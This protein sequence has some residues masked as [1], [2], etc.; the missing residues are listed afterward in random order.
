MLAKPALRRHAA[1]SNFFFISFSLE[2]IVYALLPSENHKMLSQLK[3]YLFGGGDGVTSLMTPPSSLPQSADASFI[4]NSIA[5]RAVEEEDW[6]LVD[7]QGTFT[8]IR[9]SNQRSKLILSLFADANGEMPDGLEL[10][11]SAD[12]EES[13]IFTQDGVKGHSGKARRHQRNQQPKG[14]KP[15]R[16]KA[17]NSKPSG[18]SG[19]LEEDAESTTS[20]IAIVPSP[21]RQPA[22]APTAAAAVLAAS[23]DAQ[24]V[25]AISA[26]R[27]V[28]LFTLFNIS[29]NLMLSFLQAKVK[30][31]K[32]WLSRKSLM[33]SNQTAMAASAGRNQRRGQLMVSRLCGS[34]NNRKSHQY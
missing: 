28:K 22:T 19:S 10:V 24:Q 1:S 27:S 6:V 30:V 14:T 11:T 21:E 18:R 31:D 34:N 5:G 17:S 3:S 25:A 7:T 20:S 12:C 8:F 29:R 16:W 33:R 15:R 26:A 4:I 13:W 2:F 23:V 9:Y 32:N